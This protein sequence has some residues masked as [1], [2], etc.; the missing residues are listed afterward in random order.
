MI[1]IVIRDNEIYL[2]YRWLETND[3]YRVRSKTRESW[4]Y[5]EIVQV[6]HKSYNEKFVLLSSIPNPTRK[7]LPSE[8]YLKAIQKEVKHDLNNAQTLTS[9]RR[10]EDKNAFLYTKNYRE[11][12]NEERRFSMPV[13]NLGLKS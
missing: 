2:S 10:A 4:V 13:S 11:H 1:G 12:A 7:K 5:R 9:I 6:W 8:S 3:F